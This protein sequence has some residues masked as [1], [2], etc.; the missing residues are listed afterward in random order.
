MGYLITEFYKNK[1]FKKR[2]RKRSQDWQKR[3]TSV[4]LAFLKYAEFKN[5]KRLK[6]IDEAIYSAYINSLHRKN[7]SKST[8][9]Q[10]KSI[11]KQHLLS[12][13]QLGI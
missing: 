9:Q 1:E 4:L 5:I 13:F 6:D 12:H 8:I 2:S 11:L 3:R 10:Y 7:L